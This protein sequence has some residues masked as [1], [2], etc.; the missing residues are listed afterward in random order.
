MYTYGVVVCAK[1]GLDHLCI[2]NLLLTSTL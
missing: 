2:A 1:L